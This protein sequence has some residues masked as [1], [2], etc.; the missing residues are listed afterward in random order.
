M[1]RKHLFRAAATASILAVMVVAGMAITSLRARA[2]ERDE[3]R[4]E[5]NSK[6]QIGFDIAPVHLNLAGKN[7]AL[8]GLGSFIVN[9][10]ADCNGCHTHSPQT[11][12]T[13]SG[14][15]YLLSPPF[16]GQKM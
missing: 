3:Q 10:Q 12:F 14:N 16:S 13:P 8:V 11:E 2:D 1:L 7:R 5:E 4:D 9:A 6:I 15:P